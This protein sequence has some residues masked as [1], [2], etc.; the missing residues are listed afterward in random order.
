MPSLDITATVTAEDR[1]AIVDDVLAALGPLL[2]G[3]HELV[4][5]DELADRLKVSRPTVDRC[6]ANGLIPSV[7]IGSRRL[8][9]PRAVIKALEQATV[10]AKGVAGHE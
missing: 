8:Y 9:N 2:P 5:G 6:R 10:N 4:D 3:R 1:R 7:K